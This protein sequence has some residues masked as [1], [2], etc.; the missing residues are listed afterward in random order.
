MHGK[1]DRNKLKD[2]ESLQTAGVACK[3]HNRSSRIEKYYN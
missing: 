3:V 1:Y 2:G